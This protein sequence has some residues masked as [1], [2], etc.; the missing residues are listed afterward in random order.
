MVTCVDALVLGCMYSAGV[1]SR[2]VR[3]QPYIYA[4]PRGRSR[5][6]SLISFPAFGVRAAVSVVAQTEQLPRKFWPSGARRWFQAPIRSGVGSNH[7]AVN[8][9]QFRGAPLPNT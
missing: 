1:I 9:C 8:F 2:H 7:T 4:G 5:G 6:A 3:A